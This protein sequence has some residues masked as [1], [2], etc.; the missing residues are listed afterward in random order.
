MRTHLLYLFKTILSCLI[1]IACALGILLF[2]NDVRNG[3][4][5]GISYCL[6]TLVAFFVSVYGTF[7]LF[8]IHSGISKFIGS[9]YNL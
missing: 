3:A 1:I 8:I 2:P 5:N 7:L 9:C 4:A 6:Y